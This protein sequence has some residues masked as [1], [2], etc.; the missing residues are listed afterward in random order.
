MK[1]PV[2][3]SR[4]MLSV[5]MLHIID[6]DPDIAMWEVEVDYDDDDHHLKEDS[7][8]KMRVDYKSNK[9]NKRPL[10][11]QAYAKWQLTTIRTLSF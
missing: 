8:G 9:K 7:V 1:T 6:Y 2:I 3:V 4:K 11:Q 10:P 5:F